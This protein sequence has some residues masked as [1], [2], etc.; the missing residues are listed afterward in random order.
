[1]EKALAEDTDR[2]GISVAID[3]FIRK[4]YDSVWFVRC[5]DKAVK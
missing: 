1:M 3:S 2:K 4:R 5:Y